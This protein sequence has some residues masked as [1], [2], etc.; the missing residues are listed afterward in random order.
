VTPSLQPNNC[1]KRLISD[2]SQCPHSMPAQLSEDL[3]RRIVK[4]YF[5]D[6]LTYQ[7]IR[8]QGNVSLGL[9]SNTIRN[10]CA[11]DQVNNPF[12]RCTG[13]PSYLNSEDMAFIESTLVANP[14]I[15]LNELQKRLYDTRN[16]EVSI[17]TLS[18]ALASAQYTRKWLTKASAER[19]E[20]L[21]GVWEIAMAEYTDPTVF[22]FLDESAV[23]N[24]TIQQSHGWSRLGQPCVRRMIFL[25]GKRYSILPVLTTDSI[26][27]LEIFE[28]SITKERFL[29]FLRTHIVRVIQVL[30]YC[31][32]ISYTISLGPQLNPSREVQC[33]CD[34]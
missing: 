13:Q 28:G 6:G 21:Q 34:G 17:A 25:R 23:D 30:Y 31:S 29:A 10:Y 18:R 26:I 8:D 20:E 14:S 9:I 22:V 24:K 2:L 1:D 33:C 3:K 7:D 12:R 16:L 11:F 4:W 5:E 15:Y 27:G 19:D 32:H